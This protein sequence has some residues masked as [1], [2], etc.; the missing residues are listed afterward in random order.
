MKMSRLFEMVYILMDKKQMTAGE[1]AAYFEVSVR[2]VYRDM[3][4]LSEA[5]IPIYMQKGKGGGIRLLPEFVLNKS[6]LTEQ[7]KKDI[8]SS[9]SA[10]EAVQFS[11]MKDTIHKIE[12]LFGEYNTDWI[13]VDFGLWADGEK[14]AVLFETIKKAILRKQVIQF[15]YA[16]VRGQSL[17]RRVEPLKLIFKGTAWYVYGFCRVREDFRFF[18]L[19][20]M[21][22]LVLTEEF[23]ERSIP[24]KIFVKDETADMN[25]RRQPERM[26][27]K[28]KIDRENAY[29]A[30]DDFSCCETQQDGSVI[31]Q[32][33]LAK[34]DWV[35]EHI[36]SY[37][38]SCEVLEP[39]E[40][41]EKIQGVLG[42]MLEKYR[43]E[44][45]G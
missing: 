26:D 3:E 35:V 11:T 38:E 32:A 39:K 28:L 10:L 24:A 13:E 7:E 31:V 23:H 2:T 6:V 43:S 37:G 19:K 4:R 30:Y 21:Q 27:V 29:R 17:T 9:L 34:A 41:R 1:F 5:G 15:Q 20:R 42:K 12:K 45:V 36:L 14:E 8:L 16:S 25:G 33:N 18:K 40:L 22:E 44:P